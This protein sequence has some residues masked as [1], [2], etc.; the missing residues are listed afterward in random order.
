MNVART[1][2]PNSDAEA[3]SAD[4]PQRSRPAAAFSVR[5]LLSV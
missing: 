1:N 3:A 2:E 4:I 5:L